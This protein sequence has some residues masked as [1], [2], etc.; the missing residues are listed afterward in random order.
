MSICRAW[1]VEA[2]SQLKLV[3]DSVQILITKEITG[4]RASRNY[5]QPNQQTHQQREVSFQLQPS[6]AAG[7]H[8]FNSMSRAEDTIRREE[9]KEKTGY[10]LS[11]WICSAICYC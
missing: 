2:Q 4:L 1:A 7:I 6:P 3:E 8:A 5:L 11:R 9:M 10:G